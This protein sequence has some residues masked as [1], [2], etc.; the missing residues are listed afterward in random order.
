MREDLLAMEANAWEARAKGRY[1][2][3][4]DLFTHLSDYTGDERFLGGR[5]MAFA[6]LADYDSALA[7]FRTVAALK[8]P[9]SRASSEYIIEGVCLWCL[10]HTADAIVVW[11]EAARAPFSDAAGG[12][13]PPAMLLYAGTR[14]HDIQVEKRALFVLRSKWRNHLRRLQRSMAVPTMSTRGG[15]DYTGLGNWP[16]PIVPHLLGLTD[17]SELYRAADLASDPT[18]KGGRRCQADFYAAVRSLRIGDTDAFQ[19]AITRCATSPFGYLQEECHLARW[20]EARHFPS[21]ALSDGTCP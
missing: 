11:E 9:R 1:Q 8:D 19:M 15:L 16:G 6:D 17:R 3:A 13:Q 20:E 10:G 5:G 14:R 7:D 18:V 4:I 2:Q 21:T 12:V